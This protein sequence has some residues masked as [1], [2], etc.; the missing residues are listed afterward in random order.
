MR[1]LGSSETPVTTY[2]TIHR[3]NQEY[4]RPDV[5]L[6]IYCSPQTPE[7]SLIMCL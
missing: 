7:I 3:H 4:S 6:T 2:Q 5:C 1:S